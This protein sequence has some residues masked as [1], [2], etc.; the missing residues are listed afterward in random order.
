VLL[1]N[2]LVNILASALATNA[3]TAF[4]G[5]AGV[6]YATII[7][8]A[9]VLIFAEVLPKT[10]AIKNSD[11]AALAA[12][13]PLT[14]VVTVFAPIVAGVRWLVRSTLKLFGVSVDADA[15]VLT[16]HDE[17]RGAIAYHHKEG[18]VGAF[19]HYGVSG[20]LDLPDVDV[21]EIMVHR[22]A[23]E[24]IDAD[25]KPEEIFQHVV[26]SPHTRIPLYRGDPENIVGL[27]HTKDLLRAYHEVGGDARAIDIAKVQ[28][29]PWF[30]PETTSLVAQLSAFLRK[31]THFALVVDEYGA[32]MGLVT[33]E[34]ILEEI[35]GEIEDEYDPRENGQDVATEEDGAI[36]V[37]GELSVR[38]LNRRMDWQLPDD[39]AATV[40]GLIL[41]EAQIIPEE[42]QSFSF[43]GFRFD[44]LERE[45]NQITR[46]RV[47]PPQ[48]AEN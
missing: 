21:S 31:R 16:A 42:G 39:I 19:E 8:T 44:I 47:S 28:R 26:Q 36:V 43:F 15:H 34:D 1:G 22:T 45:R 18:E 37:D 29:K 20:V 6:L 3:F 41:H 13:R 4:L 48:S 11:K 12:G 46:V 32:L 27:L 38:D 2:N 9:L 7:M 35:V 40:A 17:L 30:T 14:V 33:L 23:I 25:S 10:Y 5:D 24:M